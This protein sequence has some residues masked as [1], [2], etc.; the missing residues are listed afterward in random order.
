MLSN[1]ISLAELASKSPR[2]KAGLKSSNMGCLALLPRM[3][4]AL[5]AVLL[6]SCAAASGQTPVKVSY[7]AKFDGQSAPFLLPLDKGYYKAE[8]LEVSVDP[9]ANSA[10]AITRVNSGTYDIG[11]ADINALIQFRDQNPASAPKA[12]FIV[13]NRPAYAI[14][15]RKSRGVA[16]PR[17]LE[18]KKLGAPLADLAFAQWKIFAK[19]NEIDTSK[20][21]I[22]NIGMPV[23]E[24]MLA[25][26]QVDAITGSSFNSFVNLKD[27]GVPV[28]D[29]VVFL[30]ADYGVQLYGS[31]IIVNPKFAAD[32]PDAVRAFLRAF[33]RGM[34]ETVKDPSRAIDSVLKRNE[35]AKKDVEIERLRIAIRENLVTEEVKT[36]GYGGID[37]ARFDAAIDQIAQSYEFKS[38]T[39][40]SAAEVFDPSFLPAAAERRAN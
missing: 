13:Y 6:L 11:F 20:V 15:A 25:A 27:R 21:T 9:G 18:G 30:M 17:D 10:E 28:D 35:T 37:T 39:K 16:Q 32:N 2:F 36:D 29:V 31:A 4:T 40:P 7:D 3:A 38:K 26:G 5:T 24:P 33:T 14:I 12:V 34:K 19:A 1:T 8:G 22:D 23:R